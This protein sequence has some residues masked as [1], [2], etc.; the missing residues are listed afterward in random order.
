MITPFLGPVPRGWPC[1]R[2]YPHVATDRLRSYG[3][4]SVA[5]KAT[6]PRP[7]APFLHGQNSIT[8]DAR[9]GV[10]GDMLTDLQARRDGGPSPRPTA[11]ASA[12]GAVGTMQANMVRKASLVI[13][14]GAPK[15]LAPARRSSMANW[16]TRMP[17]THCTTRVVN[18]CRKVRSPASPPDVRAGKAAGNPG[19]AAGRPWHSSR[20]M[21]RGNL[22][23]QLI[24]ACPMF[25]IRSRRIR[26]ATA[27]RS[28]MYSDPVISLV[29]Q[30]RPP[31]R[32]RGTK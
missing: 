18:P 16:H 20:L 5:S 22:P 4:R 23:P 32:S 3:N 15:A 8:Y 19:P 21:A 28:E 30:S 6:F 25:S 2:C 31:Q 7:S 12:G 29:R 11:P 14:T 9:H 10:P 1:L 13:F 27:A 26:T 17:W 24:C